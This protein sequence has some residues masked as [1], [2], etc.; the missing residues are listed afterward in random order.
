MKNGFNID[1]PLFGTLPLG[2]GAFF[3]FIYN[4]EYSDEKH[5]AYNGHRPSRSKQKFINQEIIK[6]DV[7]Q[8]KINQLSQTIK[9]LTLMEKE[10]HERKK[11]RVLT[12][13]FI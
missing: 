8:F 11:L 4:K 7:K 3:A 2:D 6:S 10:K 1:A 13:T 5:T 9:N 12:L